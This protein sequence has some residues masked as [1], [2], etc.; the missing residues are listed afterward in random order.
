VRPG[1]IVAFAV[2]IAAPDGSAQA[3]EEGVVV[4]VELPQKYKKKTPRPEALKQMIGAVKAEV[5]SPLI[6]RL[7]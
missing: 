1:G 6:P 5:S 2:D 7:Q 4:M 3:D